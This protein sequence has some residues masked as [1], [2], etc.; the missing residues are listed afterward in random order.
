M[1]SNR[2]GPE[3]GEEERLGG[4]REREVKLWLGLHPFASFA[5]R[6][7]ECVAYVSMHVMSHVHLRGKAPWEWMTSISAVSPPPPRCLSPAIAIHNGLC[8]FP[9]AVGHRPLAGFGRAVVPDVPSFLDDPSAEG[10][11]PRAS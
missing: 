2:R 1:G 4:E 10:V 7:K 3:Q 6:P 8:S 5:G 11:D 9:D